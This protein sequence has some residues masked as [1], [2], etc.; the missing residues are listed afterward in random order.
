MLLQK[1]ELPELEQSQ[2]WRQSQALPLHKRSMFVIEK[3]NEPPQVVAVDALMADFRRHQSE[4]ASFSDY[5]EC[6]PQIVS[7]SLSAI[8]LPCCCECDGSEC[9]EHT[10]SPAHLFPNCYVRG[11]CVKRTPNLPEVEV[12]V[13]ESVH[14]PCILATTLELLRPALS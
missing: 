8:L 12:R 1:L 3:S 9:G 14:S 13:W 6:E 2:E 7:I 4:R 10:F 5:M 11:P